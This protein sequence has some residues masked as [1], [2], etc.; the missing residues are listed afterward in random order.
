MGAFSSAL[1]PL[2]KRLLIQST[3]LQQQQPND[4]FVLFFVFKNIMCIIDI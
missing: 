2:I 1:Q 4:T 3:L